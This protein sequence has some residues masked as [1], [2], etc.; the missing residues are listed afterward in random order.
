LRPGNRHY[1]LR[2]IT[3]HSARLQVVARWMFHCSAHDELLG[4]RRRQFGRAAQPAQRI[5]WSAE[6]HQHG[7]IVV[8]TSKVARLRRGAIPIGRLLAVTVDP[9]ALFVA[10]MNFLS[11]SQSRAA[12]RPYGGVSIT[13]RRRVLERRGQG[14]NRCLIAPLA[15]N[16]QSDRQAEFV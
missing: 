13:P 6:R 10:P 11:F 16:L 15:D 3:P 12:I 1:A 9:P 2:R 4:A 5:R 8:L 14:Q 7:R